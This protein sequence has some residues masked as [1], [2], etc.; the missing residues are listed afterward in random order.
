MVSTVHGLPAADLLHDEGID[1]HHIPAQGALNIAVLNL[2]P[3]KE[4]TERQL[5]RALSASRHDINVTWL[6]PATHT[7]RNTPT[8]HL[9]KYYTTFQALE[10]GNIHIDGLIVT[11]APIE[12]LEFNAVDYW[13]ELCHI[14]DTISAA[15]IPA[16]LL[17]WAAFAGLYHRFGIEKHT[18][19]H[20]ISGVFPH[21]LT[22]SEHPLAAGMEPYFHIPQSRHTE[23]HRADV[24]ATPGID[25]IAES[26][27]S[28]LYLM[29]SG[30]DNGR[31]TYVTGHSEYDAL[32][33]DSEYRRDMSRGLNPD[34][35]RHYYPEDN[36]QTTPHAAW[37][38]HRKRLFANWA[39]LC[40]RFRD[41]RGQ[42]PPHQL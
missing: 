28:G 7:P 10:S 40:H 11:G 35:P 21:H 18:L 20:K 34:I 4:P 38:G 6:I 32:T 24:M 15:H 27:E 1:I 9:E 17:C 37:E 31:E 23:I 36:P 2:M 13:P 26:E 8:E 42:K 29:A 41:V 5:L 12:K 3:L 22:H 39:D 16:L 19:A 30:T 14:L 33:L 25:I